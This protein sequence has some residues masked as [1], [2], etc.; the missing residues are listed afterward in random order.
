[1]NK[2]ILILSYFFI[3]ESVPR[4][5]RTF[6][7]AKELAKKGNSVTIYIPNYNYDYTELCKKH[8]F[9]IIKINSGF[10]LNKNKKKSISKQNKSE[11]YKSGNLKNKITKILFFFFGEK[12]IEYSLILFKN[13]LK[14]KE[15]YDLLISISYPI[16]VHLGAALALTFNK[17]L[18]KKKIAD[19]GDPFYFHESIKLAVYFKYLERFIFKKFDYITIP[20]DKALNS[21]LYFKKKDKIKI[22]PQGFDFESVK[23]AVYKKNKITTFAYAGAFDSSYRNPKLLFEYLLKLKINFKFLIFMTKENV[24]FNCIKN[25]VKNLE[26]KLEL[27]PNT[28]RDDVIFNLSKCDF[29]INVENITTNQ[30]PSKIIDYVLSKRPIYTFYPENFNEKIFNDFLNGKYDNGYNFDIKD[31]NIKKVAEQFLNLK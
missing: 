3:P 11:I 14:I 31:Y 27:I 10:F 19:C 28:P 5:F 26:D 12:K 25:Y 29:L 18:A 21:Y 6:E 8:N 1:M 30:I 22:I 7:L 4:S 17:N 16:F 2:K 20:T 24:T 9:R 13:L 15:N 23:T